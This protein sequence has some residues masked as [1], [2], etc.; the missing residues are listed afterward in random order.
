MSQCGDEAAR[1]VRGFHASSSTE[2]TPVMNV[3]A[4][5]LGLPCMISLDK[6][7]GDFLAIATLAASPVKVNLEVSGNG[8]I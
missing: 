6:T 8:F 3:V 4:P 5:Q 1:F 2:G 7:T